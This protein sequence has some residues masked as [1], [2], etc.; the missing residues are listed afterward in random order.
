MPGISRVGMRARPALPGAGVTWVS[1]APGGSGRGRRRRPAPEGRLTIRTLLGTS[2][3][4][5]AFS[6]LFCPSLC[7]DLRHKSRLLSPGENDPGNRAGR[8]GTG[9]VAP[10]HSTPVT[11]PPSPGPQGAVTPAPSSLNILN[12]GLKTCHGGYPD[13]V[14]PGAVQRGATAW[15]PGAR[16]LRRAAFRAS[17]GTPTRSVRNGRTCL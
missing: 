14:A 2:G 16:S 1:D 10:Y 15:L 9:T 4:S 6:P 13:D 8:S 7:Q 12:S 3:A 5:P 17:T 11:P